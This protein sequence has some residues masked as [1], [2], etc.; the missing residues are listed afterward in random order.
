MLKFGRMFSLVGV[1]VALPGIASDKLI[2]RISFS[3]SSIESSRKDQI[4][5]KVSKFFN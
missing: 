2:L 1:E 4:E 5:R 3:S